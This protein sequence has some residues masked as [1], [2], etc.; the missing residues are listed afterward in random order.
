VNLA[1]PTQLLSVRQ[2]QPG[3]DLYTAV[4]WHVWLKR[5]IRLAYLLDRRLPNTANYVVLFSTDLKQSAEDI[6]QLYRLRF[7]SWVHF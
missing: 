4:V 1:D 5:K 6:Y 7:L 2:V 3:I